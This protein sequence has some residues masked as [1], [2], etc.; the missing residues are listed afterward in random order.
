MDVT[1]SV[2]GDLSHIMLSSM[3]YLQQLCVHMC[4][5]YISLSQTVQ[6][7]ARL[8]KQ[9]KP[10]LHNPRLCFHVVYFPDCSRSTVS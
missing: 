3:Q 2:L 5:V 7:I 4:D 8:E 6:T 10:H 1:V 9:N